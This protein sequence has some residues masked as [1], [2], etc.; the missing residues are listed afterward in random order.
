MGALTLGSRQ[1]DTV[2]QPELELLTAI[3]QQIGMAIENA[4][5]YRAAERSAEELT[6]LHQ[7]SIFLTSTLDSAEI[8][9]Q[10]TEQSAKLL[11]C[12]MACVLTWDEA[13][14]R[15]EIVSSYGL[16]ESQGEI[17]RAQPGASDLL[18]DLATHHQSVA[19]GD[20][21]ADPRVPLA[22]REGL[23][24]RALLCV[25]IWGTEEPL[26]TL[27]LMDRHTSRRWRS[28]ELELIESFVN[29]AAVALVNANLHEQ[30][31][32]AAALEERQRIAE[33][34]HDGLAQTVSILG[35][36]IDQA[37][38]HVAAGSSHEAVEELRHIREIVGR[39]SVDVRR[40]IASLHEPPQPRHSLQDLLSDLPDQLPPDDGPSV[41]FTNRVHEPLF[42]S[43]EQR[44]QALP[45]VQEALL[46]ARRHAQAQRIDLVLERRDHEVS[47]T[48][49]DDGRGFDPGRRRKK[50]QGHFGLSIMRARAARIGGKLQVDSA[51]GQGTHVILT[52]PL[53]EGHHAAPVGFVQQP[54]RPQIGVSQGMEQ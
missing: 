2:R 28:E 17:V 20:V 46:N 31:E 44:A 34:M 7:V 27:F 49:Q 24:V 14:Q 6:L 52:W 42:L 33:D 37:T 43:R 21:Q 50:S 29:R 38:Q 10:I 5:L 40:S 48:V 45:V 53:E 25:P 51:P 23:G 12:Q 36:Q 18:P 13:L 4:R 22:W 32:W 11:G 35:L 9:D 41:A 8:Q 3:G 30:L 26:G 39:V 54:S 1:A 16:T 15:T 47:I 19:V